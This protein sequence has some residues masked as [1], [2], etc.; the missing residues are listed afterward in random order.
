MATLEQLST[1]LVNADKAGDVPAAK[2]LAAEISRMRQTQ[3]AAPAPAP[4]PEPVSDPN[5]GVVGSL[6]AFGRSAANMAGLGFMDEIGAAVDSAGSKIFPW[7]TPKTYDEALTEGRADDKRIAEEH[8]VANIAGMGAG[9]IGLGTGIVRA[10]LS[11]TAAVANRGG[12]LLA[13]SLASA[14]EGGTLGAAQGFGEGEGID[15]RLEKAKSGGAWGTAIGGVLPGAISLG[16]NA[17]RRVITPTTIAPER[18]ALTDALAREGVDVSAGQATGNAGLRYAESEIGGQA[19][20]DMM[21]R[22]GEQFTAAALRRA[23]ATANRASP[24][25]I[26]NNF[27]RIGQEFDTLA[28]NNQLHPDRRLAQDLGGA[29]REYAS[30]VPETA[31]APVVE[32]MIQDLGQTLSQGPL[33]GAA[34]QAARSRLDRYA[35]GAAADPQLQDAL[36]GIRNALD[37]AMERTITNVN[38]Q[39]LGRWQTARR[40]YRNM[41]TIER[42][43][44]GAGENAALGLISPS[45]LRNATVVT[46]G[47]RAYG[48]GNGDF[49]E[50]ARAGEG[51]MK[52]M[53]NSG[54]AG[55]TRAQN[56]GTG[57]LSTLGAIGGTSVA[58]P[59]AGVA[60]AAVGAM[61]P[62]VVGQIMMSRGGQAYL[63]NQLLRGNLPAETRALIVNALNSA[64]SSVTPDIN[65]STKGL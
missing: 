19:A 41:L 56:L 28:A 4:A 1:A 20:Q 14:A 23:G 38:P 52:S 51:V 3:P 7:R 6:E 43:A 31:R 57:L 42:A 12:G 49:A 13:T 48:R 10:G 25:V 61:T 59:M 39:D 63:R 26:D 64:G 36:Y 46:Q 18:Q 40:Q 5:G 37:D 55:R 34:Y 15:D 21:E 27:R 33:D 32:S 62:R 30:L 8:P 16:A 58:G 9:A 44:T 47:R 54:T 35:R 29:W 24:E 17:A 11:P 60:G 50:L 22:Q 45:Q 65:E 53:P 2:A